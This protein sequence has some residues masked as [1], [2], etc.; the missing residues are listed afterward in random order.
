MRRS[1]RSVLS[2]AL[3]AAFFVQ[4]T[5][6]ADLAPV[7]AR[8]MMMPPPGRMGLA[9]PM[10]KA[11]PA[12]SAKP[13]GEPWLASAVI[14]ARWVAQRLTAP[15]AEAAPMPTPE[16]LAS[17]SSA[18]NNEVAALAAAPEPPA[19]RMLIAMEGRRLVATGLAAQVASLLQTRRELQAMRPRFVGEWVGKGSAV[20]ARVDYLKPLG[21]TR[22]EAKGYRVT[23]S[24][25]YERLFPNRGALPEALMRELPLYFAGDTI[26]V[27]ITVLNTGSTPLTNLRV[28]AVQEEFTATGE[29][30]KPTSASLDGA[31]TIA[32]GATAVV[33][34][35]VKLSSEGRDAVNF[36]QTH[37][38]ISGK[39]ATG[40]DKVLLDAPQAGIVDPPGQ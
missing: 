22:G 28:S 25:G 8:G 38:R 20:Q 16:A 24:D 9:M 5:G 2:A 29:A 34:W 15:A 17:F 3:C 40:A 39:D 14:V 23:L 27:E 36:E 30:G 6:A 10:P 31:A 33:R 1:L 13:A 11:Q 4:S 21:M 19:D 7:F 12:A 35:R 37:L 18:A 26:D 32:P